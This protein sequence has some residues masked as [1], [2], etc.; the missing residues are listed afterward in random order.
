MFLRN[1]GAYLRFY[2]APKT[3]NIIIL[4]A[5]KTSNLT[6]LID[7]L[8]FSS[9]CGAFCTNETSVPVVQRGR[10]KVVHKT[11]KERKKN[12]LHEFVYVN[13]LNY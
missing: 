8:V 1:V 6:L 11:K 2:T 5:V 9:A 12:P 13:I 7:G 4:T 10:T 3:K